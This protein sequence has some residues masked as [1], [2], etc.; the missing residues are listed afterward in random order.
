MLKWSFSLFLLIASTLFGQYDFYIKN[1][2]VNIKIDK[3]NEYFVKEGIDVFFN[4]P[5]H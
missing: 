2:Q 3:K 5:R 4:E 1:Y